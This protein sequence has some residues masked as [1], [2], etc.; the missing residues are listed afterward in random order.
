M[1]VTVV[2]QLTHSHQIVSF[3][4]SLIVSVYMIAYNMHLFGKC[5]LQDDETRTY[6][7]AD[8]FGVL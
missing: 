8:C 3:I 5:P 6:D 4:V 2:P 1:D 7:A